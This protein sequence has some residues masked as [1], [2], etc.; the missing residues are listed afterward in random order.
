MMTNLR[1]LK[2]AMEMAGISLLSKVKSGDGE[3][4][5]GSRFR[6]WQFQNK[7]GKEPLETHGRTYHWCT[8]N[9]HPRPM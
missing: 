6:P 8:N 7:E 9:C 4:E 3:K 5:L 2:R 1:Q